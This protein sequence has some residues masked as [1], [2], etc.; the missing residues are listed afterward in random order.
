[1]IDYFRL[2]IVFHA[3]NAESKQ[4]TKSSRQKAGESQIAESEKD[5]GACMGQRAWRD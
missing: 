2:T 3:E 1:M 4:K 5:N